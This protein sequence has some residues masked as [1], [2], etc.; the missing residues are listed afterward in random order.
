[1]KIILWL[2]NV[3]FSNEKIKVTGTWIIAMGKALVETGEVSLFNICHGNVK[4]VT[5]KEVN[6]IVQWVLPLEKTNK[7]GLPSNNTQQIVRSI[8]NEIKPDLVHIWGTENYWG[9]LVINSTI[10]SK[11]LLEMQGI[12]TACARVYYGGLNLTEIFSCIGIKEL[13]LPQRFLYFRKKDFEKRGIREIDI[14]KNCTNISVQSDWVKAHI[15]YQNTNATVYPTGMLLREEFYNSEQWKKNT[16]RNKKV[17][18]TSFS[19]VN[20]Y[21]GLHVLMRA[22]AFLKNKYSDLEFRIGGN[23]LQT[24]RIKDGYF[25]WLIKEAKKLGIFD[26]IVWLGS[27]DADKIITELQNCDVFVIPSYIET[28][29]LAIAESMMVGTP[30]VVSFAGA[31]PELAEHNSSA[32]FF[33]VGDSMNCAY[34]TE[35]LLANI[36]LCQKLSD[37]ARNKAL[38]R[39][40]Q[41]VVVKRQLEIYQSII[42]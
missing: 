38:K 16:Q 39:N 11:T 5:K 27:L 12:M 32:L 24:K 34:Q 35:L 40:N 29:C 23:I 26:S 7:Q 6:G 22:F 41:E 21:K 36:N 4:E 15:K 8:E 28:Y 2:S 17:I 42:N 13:L 9:K 19:G 1:M 33:P 3:A 18:F 31:M 10:Q 25:V 14:I 20:P 37:N 30:T